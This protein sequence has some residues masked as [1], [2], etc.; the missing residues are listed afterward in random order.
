MDK[1][2]NKKMAR[3]CITIPQD[4]L[5]DLHTYLGDKYGKAKALSMFVVEAIEA[6]LKTCRK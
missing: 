6:K 3:I 2:E 1:K 4:S 5:Y